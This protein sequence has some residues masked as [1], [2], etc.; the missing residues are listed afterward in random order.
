MAAGGLPKKGDRAPSGAT[1]VD[2]PVHGGL[3]RRDTPARS[4]K[5]RKAERDNFC[6]MLAFFVFCHPRPITDTYRV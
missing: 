1:P 2:F 5:F 3:N 6:E 4:R